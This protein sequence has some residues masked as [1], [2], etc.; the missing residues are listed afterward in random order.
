LPPR[1][2]ILRPL[3]VTHQ[4]QQQQQQQQQPAACASIP[5]KTS[6]Q[7]LNAE[8]PLHMRIAADA[9]DT[10]AATDKTPQAST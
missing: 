9:A 6:T 4:Q 5:I 1:H 10:A 8:I 2:K 3:H 7:R